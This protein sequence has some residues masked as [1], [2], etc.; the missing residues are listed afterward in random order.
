MASVLGAMATACFSGSIAPCSD[1]RG[2]ET[3][4]VANSP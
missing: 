2:T 4:D 1:A 3:D